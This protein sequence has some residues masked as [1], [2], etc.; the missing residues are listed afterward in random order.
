MRFLIPLAALFTLGNA[1]VVHEPDE[2]VIFGQAGPDNKTFRLGFDLVPG[3]YQVGHHT[4]YSPYK[5]TKITYSSPG[6]L[7]ARD[8][9]CY[10]SVKIHD[11]TNLHSPQSKDCEVIYDRI[12][13]P[14]TWTVL[15]WLQHQLVEYRTCAYGVTAFRSRSGKAIFAHIGNDDIRDVLR[16]TIDSY[17]KEFSPHG[18]RVQSW[19]QF[20]CKPYD[21]E[22]EWEI[23]YQKGF[24]DDE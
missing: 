2:T 23:Y 14:G 19:G 11:Q 16:R 15:M 12:V 1:A 17:S 3:S 4:W 21:A 9:H 6:N 13:D 18:T 7:A 22:V 5:I 10:E 8:D 20:V 24:P